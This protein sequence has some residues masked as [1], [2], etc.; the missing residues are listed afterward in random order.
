MNNKLKNYL[1]IP[2]LFIMSVLSIIRIIKEGG[3]YTSNPTGEVNIPVNPKK[4]QCEQD[5]EK[6]RTKSCFFKVL[7]KKKKARY[8]YLSGIDTLGNKQELAEFAY[9]FGRQFDNTN[10]GDIVY[11]EKGKTYF[12]IIKSNDTLKLN[13][14]CANDQIVE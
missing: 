8:Y 5:A 3:I 1:L 4:T 12:K 9:E 6:F 7:E 10:I 14:I 2:F 11:K 13:W